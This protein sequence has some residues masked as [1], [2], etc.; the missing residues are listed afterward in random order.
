MH[1]SY[2]QDGVWVYPESALMLV[3]AGD[4]RWFIEQGFG[5]AFSRFDGV[6]KFSCD[7][8]AEPTFYFDDDAA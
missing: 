6:V 4:G 2:K 8:E 7:L 3:Q 5:A 1:L